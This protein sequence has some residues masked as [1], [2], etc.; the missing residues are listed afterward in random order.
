MELFL[1]IGGLLLLD[2]LA[3]RFGVDSR[4]LDVRDRR[5]WWPDFVNGDGMHDVARSHLALLHDEANVQRL[6]SL[7][8]A[9]RPTIRVRLAHS[10]RALA[11]A[12]EPAGC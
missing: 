5:P 6:V 3:M 4:I 8:A 2:I 7:A 1:M 11:V 10:L 12:I 9:R